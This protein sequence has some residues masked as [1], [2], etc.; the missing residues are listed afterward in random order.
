[1]CCLEHI[2][3][4][5]TVLRAILTKILPY[6][7]SIVNIFLLVVLEIENFPKLHHENSPQVAKI[8]DTR[9]GPQQSCVGIRFARIVKFGKLYCQ[10]ISGR[11]L[12]GRYCGPFKRWRSINVVGLLVEMSVGGIRYDSYN[13]QAPFDQQPLLSDRFTAPKSTDL[14]VLITADS[15]DDTDEF[16]FYLYNV[17]EEEAIV[18]EEGYVIVSCDF[19][20]P[21][22]FDQYG[23]YSMTIDKDDPD[24]IFDDEAFNH[25]RGDCSGPFG[26]NYKTNP[27]RIPKLA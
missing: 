10:R 16:D 11:K 18:Q 21:A 3:S 2:G 20:I 9:S 24:L 6:E 13:W 26:I 17:S 5:A 8:G 25:H 15:F 14:P 19:T 27:S 7:V 23:T 4:D 1:M 22:G 12:Y